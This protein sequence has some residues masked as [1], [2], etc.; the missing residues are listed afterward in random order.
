MNEVWWYLSRSSG[1]VATALIVAALVWGFLFSAKATGTRR[2]PNWWLDL[3]EYLGG[4]AVAFVVVHVVAVYQ[5]EFSGIG[6]LQIFVP[7]TAAEW[8]WGITWGVVATYLFA[9]VVVTSWPRR[10][11]S[12]RVWL[13]MHLMSVP[14]AILAAVHAWMVGS[15][16]GQPWFALLLAALVGLTTYPAALRVA[17]SVR[18]RST[19][20]RPHST[21]TL[22]PSD[23]ESVRRGTS[24]APA[25]RPTPDERTPSDLV[26][27]G[28]RPA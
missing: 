16:R 7:L 13:A 12:R 1:I 4:L 10:R 26:G 27:A 21:S 3:H 20:R 2:R 23:R 19:R 24:P 9:L 18:K 6:L 8:A 22:R 25:P 15:S 5:D 11:G 14:A 28:H 17:A